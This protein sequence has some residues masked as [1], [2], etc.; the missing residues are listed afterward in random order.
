MR[1]GA[2]E[3]SSNKKTILQLAMTVLTAISV[4]ACTTTPGDRFPG[5]LTERAQ[6][7][8]DALISGDI[9]TAYQLL[10]PGYRQ[11]NSLEQ[12]GNKLGARTIQWLG[13][14]IEREPECRQPDSCAVPVTI[15]YRV[16]QGVPGVGALD[17]ARVSQE[18]W[19]RVENQWYFVPTN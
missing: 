18:R 13:A 12:Y 8:W 5:G 9:Q 10:S 11:A 19:V 7:R 6:L 14:R 2:A 16:T 17:S 4:A 1:L 15:A 3:V